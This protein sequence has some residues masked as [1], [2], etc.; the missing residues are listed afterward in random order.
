LDTEIDVVLSVSSVCRKAPW[1]NGVA[2][3]LAAAC[4]RPVPP[5]LPPTAPVLF[6]VVTWN[7]HEG[8]GDLPRLV[9]D[10]TSGRLTGAP[11]S[12]YIL[13]LQEAIENGDHD[14]TRFAGTR[15]LSAFYSPVRRLGARVTGNAVVSTRPLI[16]PRAIDLPRQRQPRGAI[17]A[18][19]DVD[20]RQVF[21]ANAHL[22]NRVAWWRG[23]LLSD[24][25]RGRQ[26]DALL[27]AVPAAGPTIVGGDFNTW[28]GP[29][30]PAWKTLARRF[31]RTRE[32]GRPTFHDRLILD[33]LYFDLPDAW[34]V[35]QLVAPDS[36]GSDHH[37]VVAVVV[38]TADSR[39]RGGAAFSLSPARRAP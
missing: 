7:M 5:P 19:L 35:R 34:D 17:I 21:V 28:L 2:L 29:N 27:R 33:H 32:P 10:L 1:L 30:E 16:D 9:D 6:A 23:G 15:R 39:P 12:D 4:V 13:L 14:V 38:R 3:V 36:Y 26:V 20:G 24:T 8:K 31:P 37:P 22:E 11:A 18:I 25:A